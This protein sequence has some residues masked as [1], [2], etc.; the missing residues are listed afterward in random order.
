MHEVPSIGNHSLSRTNDPADIVR[1]CG[2]GSRRSLG[3]P[4]LSFLFFRQFT[5]L[6]NFVDGKFDV[7]LSCI[8]VVRGEE[9]GA[10]H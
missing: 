7:C 6:L 4:L 1:C 5:V 9:D 10:A 2:K 8:V 3:R